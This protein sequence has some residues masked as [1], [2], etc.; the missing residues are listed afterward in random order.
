M[1]AAVI[2]LKRLSDAKSRLAGRLTGA[3]RMQLARSLL[4]RTVMALHESSVVDR[5]ALVTP[6]PALAGELGL[7]G[8]PDRGGLNASLEEGARWA[9]TT[10]ADALLVLP[11]D[12]PLLTGDDIRAVVGRLTGGAR[13]VVAPTRDGGTGA[14]LVA[15]PGTLPFAFGPGSFDRHCTLARQRGL[16]VAEIRREGLALDLDTAADLEAAGYA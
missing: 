6:E 12:L 10:H 5:V 4:E 13:V 3:E 7:V 15:P 8:L 14:L 11:A 1:I 16:A 2:P 9:R